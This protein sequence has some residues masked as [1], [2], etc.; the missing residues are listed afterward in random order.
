[1]LRRSGLMG[2]HEGRIPA[3]CKG[4]YGVTKLKPG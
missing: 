4:Y 1:M 2:S 3:R